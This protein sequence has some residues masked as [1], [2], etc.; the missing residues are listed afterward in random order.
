VLWVHVHVVSFCAAV[1][2][3]L[4]HEGVNVFWETRLAIE[5]CF[6]GCRPIVRDVW[7]FSMSGCAKY[8]CTPL[9]SA[10]LLEAGGFVESSPFCFTKY[11]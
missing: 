4:R 3:M 2:W 7:Y 5:A 1:E 6:F 9:T 11:C 10:L 8:G